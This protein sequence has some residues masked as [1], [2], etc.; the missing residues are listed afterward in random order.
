MCE[1]P[2]VDAAEAQVRYDRNPD[3]QAANAAARENFN[4]V[5]LDR[6]QSAIG[7]LGLT[8]VEFYDAQA[9]EQARICS[10][11]IRIEHRARLAET[12]AGAGFGGV[13]TR[14]THNL[15]VVDFMN[16]SSSTDP[17]VGVPNHSVSAM[18]LDFYGLS[19]LYSADEKG[20]DT[21]IKTVCSKLA[22]NFHLQITYEDQRSRSA[23]SKTLRE[24]YEDRSEF[25][26]ARFGRYLKA[27]KIKV[28]NLIK[29]PYK[30]AD[31]RM[32]MTFSFTGRK[33]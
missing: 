21:K 3:K 30:G 25:V 1:Y 24:V 23:W 27:R 22:D 18:F 11:D 7:L 12:F 16:W 15:N 28:D 10:Y 13:W 9:Y 33:M 14:W 8:D 19:D 6:N 17:F 32:M 20:R 5:A 26:F 2:L 31:K 29:A 4:S